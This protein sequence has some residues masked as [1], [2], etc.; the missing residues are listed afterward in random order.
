MKNSLIFLS[1]F[2]SGHLLAQVPAA[3]TIRIPQ[4]NGSKFVNRDILPDAAGVLGWTGTTLGKIYTS[5]GGNGAADNGKL[6]L[7]SGLGGGITAT[8]GITVKPFGG[9]VEASSLTATGW[10]FFDGTHTL[11]VAPSALTADRNLSF[12][13]PGSDSALISTGDIGTVSDAMLAGSITPSKI[14]GT[15][16]V[17]TGNAF[18]GANTLTLNALGTTP[19][20]ALSLINT[21][22]AAAGSQQVSPSVI[23]S[24]RGWKTNATAG[25]QTVEFRSHLLPVQGAANPTADLVFQSSINGGAFTESFR[26]YSQG[27]LYAAALTSNAGTCSFQVGGGGALYASSS[28]YASS[29]NI[30][31]LSDSGALFIGTNQSPYLSREANYTL[32][33]RNGTNPMAIR[34][35]ETDNGSNDEYL[36]ISAAAG[37]NFIKP[38]KSGSGTASKTDYF[39]TETVRITSGSGSPESVVTAEV[40]SLYIRTDGGA[41][42][43]LYVKE[44]GSGDTGWAAK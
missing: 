6:V 11:Q 26:V 7:Y 13:S 42:T 32:G 9:G 12:P 37:T 24:G 25:S 18:T 43:T 34:L 27:S 44:S 36:E 39:V 20:P 5:S 8:T 31:T 35:F 3:N 33:I 23:W 21:T 1:L 2:L 30:G 41:A 15:A 14:T 10:Q 22:A 40:G 17:L 19:T 28:I 38:T 4:S 29:G 16:A